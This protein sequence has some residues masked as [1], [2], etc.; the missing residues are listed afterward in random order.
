M[1]MV[2]SGLKG[3]IKKGLKEDKAIPMRHRGIQPQVIVKYVVLTGSHG[4]GQPSD[5]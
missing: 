3:L 5:P 2:N 4:Y 1:T